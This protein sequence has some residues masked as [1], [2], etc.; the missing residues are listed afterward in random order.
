MA[1][2]TDIVQKKE[3][4][5]RLKR[6]LEICDI[7]LGGALARGLQNMQGI[8]LM[9]TLKV[10]SVVNT[11]MSGNIVAQIEKIDQELSS[12][13][14]E[15]EDPELT[16]KKIRRRMTPAEEMMLREDRSRLLL[17]LTQQHNQKLKE[18]SLEMQ[19]QAAAAN[20]K[21]GGVTKRKPGFSPIEVATT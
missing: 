13:I 7:P 11:R 18:A 2:T 15:D 12:R 20:A 21:G 3:E 4:S 5:D 1:E 9:D 10:V 6:L 8:T 14:R 16:G 17:I 19:A